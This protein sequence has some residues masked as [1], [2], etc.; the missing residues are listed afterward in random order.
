MGR[1]KLP[2]PIDQRTR[3]RRRRRPKRETRNPSWALQLQGWRRRRRRRRRGKR[4]GRSRRRRVAGDHHG[5]GA[6]QEVGG[7]CAQ[8]LWAKRRERVS[9]KLHNGGGR[10]NDERARPRETGALAAGGEFGSVRHTAVTPPSV[11]E[12]VTQRR[13]RGAGG[14]EE[15]FFC[16]VRGRGRITVLIGAGNSQHPEIGRASCRERVFRAV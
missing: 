4:R 1:A 3:P 13:E 2:R 7:R 15:L 14:G 9:A 5:E 8:C 16:R 11:V 10:R 12:K 6:Y